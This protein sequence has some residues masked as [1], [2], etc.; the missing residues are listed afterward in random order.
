MLMRARALVLLVLPVLSLLMGSE[1]A[2]K[3]GV[4]VMLALDVL[5]LRV[6]WLPQFGSSVRCVPG[7][8]PKPV[9]RKTRVLVLVLML[10]LML[11]L[12]VLLVNVMG[13]KP[14][15]RRR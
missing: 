2:L 5:V 15:G 7:L 6:L 13:F 4:L 3:K 10:V 12:L 9:L 14:W 1:A 8:M 11:M